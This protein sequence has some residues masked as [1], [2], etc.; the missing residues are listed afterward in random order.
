MTTLQPI[1]VQVLQWYQTF[2][3]SFRRRQCLTGSA[4]DEFQH[5]PAV[6][7]ILQPRF[8]PPIHRTTTPTHQLNRI[9]RSHPPSN[10]RPTQKRIKHHRRQAERL[11]YAY[12]KYLPNSALKSDHGWLTPL[13]QRRRAQNRASQ[14]AFRERKEKHVQ[15]LEHELEDLETKHRTLARSYTDLDTTASQL[16]EEVKQLR[17][18]LDSVMGSREGSVNNESQPGTNFFDP[19]ASDGMFGN[20]T[21]LGF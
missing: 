7:L 6:Q 11:E 10:R 19:F 15:H 3:L 18:E 2:I 20:G 16:R 8:I 5:R 17:S 13:F 21:E 4:L 14:R 1:Q 12:S 9:H